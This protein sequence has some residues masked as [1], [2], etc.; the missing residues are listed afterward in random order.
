MTSTSTYLYDGLGRRMEKNV[1]GAITRYLYDNEDIL[2]ELDGSN[3]ILAQYTHGPGID[4]PLIM[5]RDGQSYYYHT[6]GLGSVVAMTDASGAVVQTYR[7]DAFGGI[8]KQDGEVLNPYTYTARELDAES[9]N[10]YYRAR[11]YNA[12]TGRFFSEDPLVQ[13]S[14]VYTGN[15]PITFIDPTGYGI[16]INCF[17]DCFNRLTFGIASIPGT[18]ISSGLGIWAYLGG[19]GSVLIG[20]IL[21]GAS[22]IVM[23]ATITC[24]IICLEDE[25]LCD[26][27]YSNYDINISNTTTNV[28]YNIPLPK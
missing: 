12:Y 1:D 18:I 4:E 3:N 22:V 7:Y 19:P 11:Y 27:P 24:G 9:G 15:S 2:L 28:P 20:K 8:V 25:A 21:V 10:Y 6:D 13:G 17:K 16:D 5:E 14:Y 26:V 23:N